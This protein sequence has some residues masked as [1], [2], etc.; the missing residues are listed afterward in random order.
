ME[1]EKDGIIGG[2]RESPST[3]GTDWHDP[4]TERAGG[5]FGGVVGRIDPNFETWLQLQLVPHSGEPIYCAIGWARRIFI[6][7]TCLWDSFS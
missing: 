3:A 5:T 4:S 1:E 7:F 6:P 2:G